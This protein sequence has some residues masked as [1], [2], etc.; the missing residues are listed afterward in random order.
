MPMLHGLGWIVC[1]LLCFAVGACG[2]H[3]EETK[4]GVQ[5]LSEKLCVK[6]PANAVIVGVH[7]EHGMDDSISVRMKVDR[8]GLQFFEENMPIPDEHMKDNAGKLL[9]WSGSPEWWAPADTTRVGQVLGQPGWR[10]LEVGIDDRG[11]D[12]VDIYV[13]NGGM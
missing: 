9:A 1:W 13:V 10:S 2:G 5:E 7:T 11:A 4:L 8:A 3:T 12:H 6:L